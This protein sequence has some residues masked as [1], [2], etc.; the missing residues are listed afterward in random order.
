MKIVQIYPE[1]RYGFDKPTSKFGEFHFFPD[2]CTADVVFSWD[3]SAKPQAGEKSFHLREQ[4]WN[5]EQWKFQFKKMGRLDGNFFKTYKKVFD[6][7]VQLE[8]PVTI[9]VWDKEAKQEVPYTIQPWETVRLKAFSA[10]KIQLLAQSM[11]LTK[12]IEKVEM[13]KK[14]RTTGVEKKEMSLP[15]DW[16]NQVLDKMVGKSFEV[17]VIG[18]GLDTKYSFREISD[19]VVPTPK[20]DEI[21]IE[22]IPF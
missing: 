20:S 18:S 2:S 16:E 7:E 21:S 17:G 6:V 5:T 15:Y 14:D 12:W 1:Y 3:P 11:M 13:V 10:N 9:P 4:S 22:D 19:I 8:T